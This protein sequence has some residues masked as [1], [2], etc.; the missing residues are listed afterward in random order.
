LRDFS[1]KKSL[2]IMSRIWFKQKKQ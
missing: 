1:K 2:K